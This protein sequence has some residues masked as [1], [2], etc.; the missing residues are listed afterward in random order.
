M[1]SHRLL[2]LAMLHK[3]LG[4]CLVSFPSGLVLGEEATGT[5]GGRQIVSLYRPF[6]GLSGDKAHLEAQRSVV[7]PRATFAMIEVKKQSLIL[8]HFECA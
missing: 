1:R 8:G 2:R 3:S 7:Q 5:E 6:P 4:H